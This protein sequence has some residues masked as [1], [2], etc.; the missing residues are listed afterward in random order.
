MLLENM[1]RYQYKQ[2]GATDCERV[3]S[4]VVRAAS[5]SDNIYVRHFICCT[6]DFCTDYNSI[7]DQY[8]YDVENTTEYDIE[9]TTGYDVENTTGYAIG[10]M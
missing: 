3:Q 6:E 9:N 10:N 4:K 5:T 1:T 2:S 8:D 7:D